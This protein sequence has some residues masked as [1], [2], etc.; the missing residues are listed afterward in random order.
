MRL[1]SVGKRKMRVG[2]P[3]LKKI[4]GRMGVEGEKGGESRAGCPCYGMLGLLGFLL[5]DRVVED[6]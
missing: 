4:A 1:Y 5:P 6:I 2:W 3:E